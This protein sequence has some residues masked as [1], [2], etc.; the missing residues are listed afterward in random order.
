[1]SD[2]ERT[3]LVTGGAGYIGSTLTRKL[4]DRG[5][6]VKVLD[7]FFFGKESLEEVKDN[8]NLELI[9]GDV[10]YFEPEILEDVDVVMDLAALSNDP[11]GELDPDKT[12]DINYL[13]RARVAKLAKL[14]GVNRYIQASTCSTYGQQDGMADEESEANPLTTY[15]KAHRKLEQEV[16]PMA[17]DD[18]TVTCLRQATVYGASNRMRFD[19]AINAMTNAI[20]EDG[21]L[22]IMRDGTQWRPFVHVKD[23]ARAFIEVSEADEETVSGEIFNVGS[24]EQNFQIKPLAEMIMES[25]DFEVGWEWY[26]DPDDRSYKVDFT[27]IREKI[28]FEPKHTPADAAKEIYELLQKGELEKTEK[29]STVGWYKK[30][31]SSEELLED[32]RHEPRLL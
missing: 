2:S 8:E 3:V 7:R 22:G 10:R 17:D 26:G 20:Y 30:L 28:G 15:A 31:L 19:L 12:W 16:L 5:Y 11:A 6:E 21:E 24:N 13:G 4:L 23:T 18:F 14:K 29:T 1:M 25:F 9:E 32:K 27:K